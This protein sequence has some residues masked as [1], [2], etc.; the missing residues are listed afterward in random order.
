MEGYTCSI[1]GQYHQGLPFSYG[2][3]VPALV[4]SFSEIE[5]KKRVLLSS[6]QCEVRSKKLF[7]E[8]VYF[9]VGNIDIP[10]IDSKEIFQWTVWVSL[11]KKN[12]ARAGKLWDRAGRENEP[13]YFGWLSTLLPLSLYPE[14]LHLKTHVHTRP[15]GIRPLVE[16]EATDH[17]LALEQRNGISLARIQ[18]IAE[19]ILHPH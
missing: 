17:P 16:L 1:C 15:V 19:L 13:P 8:N 6:D 2:S 4:N 9:I 14:T 10:V 3:P 12:Y 18:E 7:G 11:S 5:R